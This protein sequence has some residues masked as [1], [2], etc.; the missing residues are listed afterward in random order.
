LLGIITALLAQGGLEGQHNSGSRCS[1]DQRDAALKDLARV[2]SELEEVRAE[3]R[4]AR[5][6]CV[7]AEDNVKL[8]A[9]EAEASAAAERQRA[10]AV[11][12]KQAEAVIRVNTEAQETVAGA[13]RRCAAA[14]S[15]AAA[16][17][18][19]EGR[20]RRDCQRLETALAAAREELLQS[21]TAVGSATRQLAE[22]VSQVC[23]CL[24]MSM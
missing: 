10:D 15:A 2:Q 5:D 11:A 18:E 3:V 19:A 20:A 13:E 1:R 7:V 6:S 24:G 9:A 4:A 22:N 21:H 8:R 16:A 14:E 12:S 23:T 17:A